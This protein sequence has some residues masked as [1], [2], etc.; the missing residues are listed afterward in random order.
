MDRASFVR[1]ADALIAILVGMVLLTVDF[2]QPWLWLVLATLGVVLL[3]QHYMRR[4]LRPQ[5]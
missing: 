5:S 2:G 3:A 4:R 1:Q